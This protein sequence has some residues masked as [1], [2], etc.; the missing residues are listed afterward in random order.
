MD[1]LVKGLRASGP[2]GF[3]PII[4]SMPFFLFSSIVQTI[5]GQ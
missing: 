4:Y 2:Y 1:L 5:K 3:E